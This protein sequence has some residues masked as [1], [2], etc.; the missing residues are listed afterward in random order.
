MSD[1]PRSTLARKTIGIVGSGAVGIGCAIHLLRAGHSVT[2]FDSRTPGSG[3]SMGNSG[4]LAISEVL[5]FSRPETLKKVPKMFLDPMGPLSIRPSYVPRI[6]PWLLQFMWASRAS[7]TSRISTALAMLLKSANADW[8]DILRGTTAQHRL[9]SNGWLRVYAT[10]QALEGARYDVALQREYGVDIDIID[11]NR[12]REMEPALAP[13][14]AGASFCPGASSL[15]MP[16]KV[17]QVLAADVAARGAMFRQ[18]TV[19]AVETSEAGARVIDDTGMRHDFDRVV[20]AAGAWSRKLVRQLGQDVMLDTERGYHLMLPAPPKNIT[21]PV[22]ISSPGYS[23][24]PMEDGLRLLTGV[25]FAG[26]EGA[27]D[28]RRIR[29][30]AEHATRVIPGLD[31]RSTS[32]WLGFRPSMPDSLPVIGP[33]RKHPNVLLAFGHGHLG[34][35]LGPLTGRLITAQIEGREPELD[36]T[37]FLPRS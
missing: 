6:T 28:F 35:T 26:V 13:I 32:D 1:T 3:A 18:A 9:K 21:R 17:L 37:P 7:K 22:T 4:I 20:V 14:F 5:P 16:Q 10:P 27:P 23:L 30:M 31:P 12:L 29:R 11:A 24:S 2:L 8:V 15:D 36:M 19:R 34:L 33:L 25:E